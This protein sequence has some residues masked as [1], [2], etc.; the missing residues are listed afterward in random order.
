MDAYSSDPHQLSYSDSAAPV[1]VAASSEMAMLKAERVIHANHLRIG[2]RLKIDEARGRVKMQAQTAAVWVELDQD[3]GDEMDALI[4]QV[5]HDVSRGFYAA[6]I[7]STAPLLDKVSARIDE[8]DIEVIV[9]ASDLERTTALALAVSRMNTPLRVSD[10]GADNSAER[11]ESDS[12]NALAPVGR[13][14]GPPKQSAGST[15]R[16]NPFAVRRYRRQ[17]YSRAASSLPVLLRRAV[18]RPRMGYA[19][20]PAPG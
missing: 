8:D 11:S 6:V 18:C 4:S 7:S 15:T 2:A 5:S 12:C 19:A 9:D 20:R 1:L 14:G 10:I 16:R 3:C 13:A 17:R